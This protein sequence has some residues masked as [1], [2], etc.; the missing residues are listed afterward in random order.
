MPHS[1]TVLSESVKADMSGTPARDSDQV[2]IANEPAPP[3]AKSAGVGRQALVYGVGEVLGKAVSFIMLPLYTSYLTPADYGVVSLVDMTFSLVAIVAG[4]RLTAGIFRFYHKADTPAERNTVISTAMVLIAVAYVIVSTAGVAFAVHLSQFIFGTPIHADVLRIA[5]VSF[6][7]QG[8]LAVPFAYLTVAEQ[9]KLFVFVNLAKL[10][11][12]ASLNYVFLAHLHLGVRSVFTSSVIA[13][14][15]FLAI[16][17]WRQLRDTG[18][19]FS[20]EAADKL[21][22]F[23]WPLVFTQIALF[24]LTY[25]DRYFLQRAGGDAAVG[26]YALAYN[27]GFLLVQ[28]GFSPFARVWD[29]VRFRIAKHHDADRDGPFSQAFIDVNVLLLAFGTGILLFVRDLLRVMSNPAFHSAADIVPVILVAY[30]LQC[31]AMMQE[32]GIMVTERTGWNTVANVLGAI[33][34]IAGYVL[35][36]PRYLGLG[37]AWATLIS[38]AVRWIVLYAASQRLWPIHY[39]WGPVGRL[40]ALSGAVGGVG[41]MFPARL[42]IVT[43]ISSHTALFIAY[44]VGLWHLGVVAESYRQR[45]RALTQSLVARVFRPA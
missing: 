32:V 43:S 7:L 12:Q 31:W 26:L 8:V 5:A 16:L 40:L 6:L 22:R 27:F 15:V 2:S 4:A 13:N 24:V 38:F 36:I 28:I 34:A 10:V 17:G 9:P 37:A 45:A 30:L 14:A 35:L 33:V 44:L 29:S 23:W 39:R 18:I 19:G 11:L 20:R 41:F 1:V 21:F 3:P 42:P 25:G